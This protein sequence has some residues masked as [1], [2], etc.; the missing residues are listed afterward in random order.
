MLERSVCPDH[1]P[2]GS[3]PRDV[4]RSFVSR[5]I[6]RW[7]RIS[8]ILRWTSAADN[9]SGIPDTI[10]MSVSIGGGG[11]RRS[12]SPVRAGATAT[13]ELEL[14]STRC[15]FVELTLRSSSIVISDDLEGDA[16]EISS[17]EAST[18]SSWMT[19]DARARRS[20]IA[21]RRGTEH[22]TSRRDI[23]RTGLL[24]LTSPNTNVALWV[25]SSRVYGD[26]RPASISVAV[27][28]GET[29]HTK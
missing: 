11:H 22:V 27:E 18:S 21:A 3:I 4:A 1:V 6:P 14:A 23:D 12:M 20:L 8:S 13:L 7:S 19:W 26:I 29:T 5:G 2:A 28:R 15:F 17:E 25:T 9:V 24:C 16:T 10:I